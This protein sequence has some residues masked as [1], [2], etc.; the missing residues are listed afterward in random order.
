[1]NYNVNDL[2]ASLDIMWKGM[3]GIFIVCG[4]I[5]LLSMLLLKVL[6]PKEKK[7]ESEA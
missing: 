6:M 3:A 7:E 5:M 2:F 1:M 4:F